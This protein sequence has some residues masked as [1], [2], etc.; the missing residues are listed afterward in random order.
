MFTLNRCKMGS[1][2]A[3]YGL[4]LEQ[5]SYDLLPLLQ[6]VPDPLVGLRKRENAA[7]AVTALFLAPVVLIKYW[8]CPPGDVAVDFVF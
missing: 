1:H 3:R 8:S 2:F 7:M 6:K 4:A 5:L